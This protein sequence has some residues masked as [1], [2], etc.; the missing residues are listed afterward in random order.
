M[1]DVARDEEARSIWGP[2]THFSPAMPSSLSTPFPYPG[3]RAFVVR[4]DSSCSLL[5]DVMGDV[6]ELLIPLS[7]ENG[8]SGAGSRGCQA[9]LRVDDRL[10]QRLAA[11]RDAMTDLCLVTAMLALVPGYGKLISVSTPSSDDGSQKVGM[12]CRPEDVPLAMASL[13]LGSDGGISVM[14]KSMD[15]DPGWMDSSPVTELMELVAGY[16]SGH[17]A[18]PRAG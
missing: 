5:A 18:S 15:D 9:H 1:G 17:A 3:T 4:R 7:S 16:R 13:V 11:A 6:K 2:S 8:A 14:C 10:L 12:H